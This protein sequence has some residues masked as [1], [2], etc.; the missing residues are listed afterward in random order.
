[1]AIQD[2]R[3]AS[4]N[5]QSPTGMTGLIFVAGVLRNTGS[6]F[7]WIDDS[8]HA[9][10]NFDVAIETTSTEVTVHFS[11]VASKVG[12]LV[13]VPDETYALQGIFCGSSV[14]LDKARIT[15]ANTSGLKDP[16]TLTSALG[17]FWVYGLFYK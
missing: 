5:K 11:F 15:F 3:I 1:M 10:L 6:G 4:L 17:N 7:F 16:T 14:D 12:T 13:V 2:V 9:P 8:S